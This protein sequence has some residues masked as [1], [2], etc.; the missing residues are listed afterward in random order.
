[1]PQTLMPINRL[2][3]RN[4]LVDT[5]DLALHLFGGESVVEHRL[6]VGEHDEAALLVFKRVVGRD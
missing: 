4:K 1:M 3:G 6:W 5:D 2:D